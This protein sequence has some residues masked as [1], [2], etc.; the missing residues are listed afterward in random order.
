MSRRKFMFW[1]V[2][3]IC[4]TWIAVRWA[5][6]CTRPTHV[7][8]ATNGRLAECSARPNCVSTQ[9][10]DPSHH[11]QPIA[12]SSSPTE[13][14]QQLAKTLGSTP[15]TRM[16]TVSDGYVHVECR[17]WLLAFID[18]VE[19]V[20]DEPTGVIHFR[21]AS[22]VGHSDAGVNRQRMEDFRRAFE[23]QASN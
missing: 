9:T 14:L 12:F 22:R 4:V 8:G 19:F 1:I 10:D 7:L 11:M 3:T 21:S 23:D 15:R 17:S 13:A 18:D 16:V 6:S 5:N 20:L 2:C